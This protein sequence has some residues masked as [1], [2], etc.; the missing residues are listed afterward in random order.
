MEKKNI[1]DK[2]SKYIVNIYFVLIVTILPLYFH[3]KYFDMVRTKADT[4]VNITGITA[5]SFIL[6][7]LVS[8]I[9]NGDMQVFPVNKTDKFVFTFLILAII[10]TLFSENKAE[11]M[12]G[13]AGW[14]VG[15]AFF[16]LCCVAYYMLSRHFEWNDRIA[17]IAVMANMIVL[18]LGMGNAVGIDPLKMNEG[19]G[20]SDYGKYLS[21]I[22]NVNWYAGYLCMLLSLCVIVFFLSKRLGARIIS[23]VV[24]M[25]CIINGIACNSD[26]F[27]L[28]T[29]PIAI[30]ILYSFLKS[31]EG[32]KRFIEFIIVLEV[33]ILTVVVLKNKFL[34]KLDSIQSGIVSDA[35]IV[36]LLIILITAVILYKADS[37]T[38]YENN[39]KISSGIV[40][41]FVMATV[42]IISVANAGSNS[43]GNS[44]LRKFQLNGAWGTNRGY[45][46][47]Y[48]AEIFLNLNPFQML[49]GIGPDTFGIIFSKYFQNEMIEIWNKNVVNAHCEPLQLLITNG[50]L[51]AAAY[52]GMFISAV[53][54]FLKK[55]SVVLKAIA[56]AII[57]Y[58]CQ[59]MINNIQGI[60]T[61]FVFVL[62]GVGMSIAL[63]E[64]AREAH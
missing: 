30:Y 8:V 4:F 12:W 25:L 52:Y 44:F 35:G 26:G 5:L 36:V 39:K 17:I 22:G 19:M 16:A 28:G 34:V 2:I 49:F 20:R 60:C 64:E 50:I 45:L 41:I 21:T 31:K 51:G 14:H 1:F 55:N 33:S 57:S 11:A 46:W 27:F 53:K 18:L 40:I 6:L 32:I 23:T 56:V 47:K 3:D 13:T 37:K 58:L 62:L 42:I 43:I 48:S 7:Q 15:T 38:I 29:I 59:G 61:P 54:V 9:L 10:S 63:R 24:L